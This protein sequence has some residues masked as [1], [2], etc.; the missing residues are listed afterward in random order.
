MVKETAKLSFDALHQTPINLA[1]CAASVPASQAAKS[2]KYVSVDPELPKSV[3]R[4]RV[5]IAGK[6]KGRKSAQAP[7]NG[8]L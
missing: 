8:E 7:G 4:K 2:T 6:N 3:G 1:K 5:P